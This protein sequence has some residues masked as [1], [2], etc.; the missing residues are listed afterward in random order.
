MN[1]KIKFVSR[2]NENQLQKI[3][4]KKYPNKECPTCHK[5]GIYAGC[6]EK[7]YDEKTNEYILLSFDVFCQECGDFLTKWDNTNRQYWLGQR[8]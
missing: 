4:E 6:I 1:R 2:I 7:Q 5:N 3:L 8:N